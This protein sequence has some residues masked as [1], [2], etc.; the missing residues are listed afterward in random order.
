MK[1]QA[2][3][4]PPTDIGSE[5]QTWDRAVARLLGPVVVPADRERRRS[6]A[7][8]L[9]AAALRAAEADDLTAQAQQRI[10]V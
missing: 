1:G 9:A 3:R 4:F 7:L 5:A 8:A 6:D 2:Y 10:T